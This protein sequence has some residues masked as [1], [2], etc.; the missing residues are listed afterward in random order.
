M[1][2]VG[3]FVFTLGQ[4][5]AIL[6]YQIS[7]KCPCENSERSTPILQLHRDRELSRQPIIEVDKTLQY[8]LE[9]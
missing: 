5:S 6:P 4:L 7:F 2:C 3:C 1:S 9:K 8:E